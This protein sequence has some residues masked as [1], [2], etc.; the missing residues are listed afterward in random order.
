MADRMFFNIELA[1]VASTIFALLWSWDAQRQYHQ[2][3]LLRRIWTWQGCELTFLGLFTSLLGIF[4]GFY[5]VEFLSS[6]LGSIG[7]AQFFLNLV[8]G[9]IGMGVTEQLIVKKLRTQS[10]QAKRDLETSSP[11]QDP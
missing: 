9:L 3:N 4:A 6:F 2:P 5:V 8:G 1:I 11:P 10:I 7:N